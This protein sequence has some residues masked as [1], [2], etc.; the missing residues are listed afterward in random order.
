MEHMK[1]V[2]ITG[3]LG[4]IFSHV[5]EYFL[6]AGWKVLVIDDLSEGS[7]PE[8]I[9]QWSKKF[10][11]TFIFLKKDVS[12][13]SVV[14]DIL[15]FNPEYIIHAAA[16]SDVDH[17]IKFPK[18]TIYT[19]N[20]ATIN[21]FEAARKLDDLKKLLYVSTDEVYG[22]CDHPKTEE[23]IIFP[24]NPY[25]L[26]KAFGSLMRIAYDNTYPEL[27]DKTVETRFCNVFGPRQDDRKVI[28]ALKR[29]LQGGKP[30]ELHNGGEGFRQFIHVNEIPRIVALLLRNG[31]RTYNITSGEGYTVRDLIGLAEEFS[32]K[33]VPVVAG[34]RSGMDIRYEMSSERIAEEFN[35]SP[36]RSFIDSFKEYLNG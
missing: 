15:K 21:I 13:M 2:V 33:R 19:N 5:S 6:T 12:S 34:K 7:H 16:I 10:G 27:K 8:L 9:D 25:A 3:G 1:K 14:D 26:S 24:K 4:F 35:W 30:L 28:P 11:D 20:L 23:D 32:G 22:E 18:S 29:A 36:S 31:N 17:S